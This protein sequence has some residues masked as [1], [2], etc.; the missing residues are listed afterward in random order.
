M[1]TSRSQTNQAHD[2]EQLI[3]DVAKNNIPSAAI[4]ERMRLQERQEMLAI[5]GELSPIVNWKITNEESHH[6]DRRQ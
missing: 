1:L 2:F 5:K 3:K 4:A 6:F